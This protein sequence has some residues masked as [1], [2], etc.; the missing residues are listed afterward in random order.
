[1]VQP[2]RRTL[3]AATLALPALATGARAQARYPVRPV[4][5]IVPWGAGGGTDATARIMGSLLE[6]ELGQPV[7]VV[8]RTGGSGVVGHSAIATAAPD[9]YTIGM[10]TVEITMMHWQG[11]TEL[12]PT[13]Y[14]PLGLVNQDPPGVQVG[15]SSP[16]Q[17]IRALA[18]A[19]RERPA[20]TFRA[21]GTG[22]GG[23]WH[24]A[25]V[26]WLQAMGLR[27]DHVRWVPSNGAAP[28]MQELAAGGVDIVTCSVPE[29]RAMLDAGRARSLAI[30]APARNPQ[31]PNVPTLNETL[32]INYSVGAWRGLAGPR[33]MPREALDALVPAIK[34]AYDSR[35]FQDF[36][37][38]R[39]FG[40]IYSDPEG[41]ARFMADGDRAM[42][43]AMRG[44]GLARG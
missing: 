43:E 12:R 25:L 5:L 10:I 42:G 16:F 23:I 26:G 20:G 30:M 17:D 11:L 29:A 22:Q 40:V 7:N 6:R 24:L 35:D 28:A 1:M 21:S 37:A 14:T 8:N 32:G 33:N 2:T 4:Q 19:I 38:S 44:A 13:S 36:M 3:A 39:G 34:R 15:S 18:Q 27:G 31:F 41:F 9:G